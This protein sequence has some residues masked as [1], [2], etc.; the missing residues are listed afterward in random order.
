MLLNIAMQPSGFRMPE[1]VNAAVATT[2]ST[3][4]L[5]AG[6][7]KKRSPKERAAEGLDAQNAAV[8]TMM[9]ATAAL[10][11]AIPTRIA[12][13]LTRSSVTSGVIVIFS[14][15]SAPGRLASARHFFLNPNHR[16]ASS[17]TQPFRAKPPP[18]LTPP[19][20]PRTRAHVLPASD[21]RPRRRTTQR[22]RT[23]LPSKIRDPLST[24]TSSKIHDL[25][26]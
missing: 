3:I 14:A 15:I 26:G 20:A 16:D 9:K 1:A 2:M 10:T 25:P 17:L 11:R 5:T 13:H 22:H 24:T 12:L 21:Q 6:G 18:E 8:P 19:S 7:A 23:P 4:V